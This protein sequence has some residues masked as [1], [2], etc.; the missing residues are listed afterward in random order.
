[1]ARRSTSGEASQ[2]SSRSGRR[3]GR[4]VT[5][6]S[7]FRRLDDHVGRRGANQ[8]P[9][10]FRA[11]TYG[12][13]DAGEVAIRHRSGTCS[14]PTRRGGA[15][16]HRW[17]PVARSDRDSATHERRPGRPGRRH[18]QRRSLVGC[19]YARWLFGARHVA[20]CIR[21]G[22]GAHDARPARPNHDHGEPAEP[23]RRD[24]IDRRLD[25]PRARP[26]LPD[27]LP[28]GYGMG[29]WPN[30]ARARRSF[31]AGGRRIPS[32]FAGR[33]R[34]RNGAC[35]HQGRARTFQLN[36]VTCGRS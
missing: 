19:R 34:P 29:Q 6:R 8:D 11:A 14:R 28:D 26:V 3:A 30:Q 36:A 21:D 13:E 22:G 7:P 9:H 12:A 23:R 10:A 35:G 2:C 1:M 18:R 17:T 5:A 4:R 27:P 15:H 25:T 31:S 24:G 33:R 32:P 20:A 16:R